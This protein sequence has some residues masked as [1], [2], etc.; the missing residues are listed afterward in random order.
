M[1]CPERDYAIPQSR[2]RVYI[3]AAPSSAMQPKSK[4]IQH[5]KRSLSKFLDVSEE[6]SEIADVP[7]YEHNHGKK[8]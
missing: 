3:V 6:G 7:T 5:S 8:W 2:P 4:P 1:Q